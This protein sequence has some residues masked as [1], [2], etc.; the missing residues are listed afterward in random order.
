LIACAINRFLYLS[1]LRLS[2]S[3]R[4]LSLFERVLIRCDIL[5]FD[6]RH[7]QMQGGRMADIQVS[8]VWFS[9]FALSFEPF[10]RRAPRLSTCPEQHQETVKRMVP[11]LSETRFTLGK[12]PVLTRSGLTYGVFFETSGLVASS[13]LSTLSVPVAG[14]VGEVTVSVA[15]E[16]VVS[17]SDCVVGWGEGKGGFANVDW[18]SE[19]GSDW[20][21]SKPRE[22]GGWSGLSMPDDVERGQEG[23]SDYGVKRVSEAKTWRKLRRAPWRVDK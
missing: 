21:M 9:H 8:F 15:T 23:R 3:F 17:A 22:L 19:T 6:V 4:R 10:F 20:T 5:S 2:L 7:M 1:H 14:V 12:P 11:M 16:L 18:A 13:T